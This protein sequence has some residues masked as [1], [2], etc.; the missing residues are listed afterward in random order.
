MRKL[1]AC[2]AAAL[3]AALTASEARA[4]DSPSIVGHYVETRT[5]EVF[6][7]GCLMNSEGETGGREALMAWRIDRGA[8]AGVPLDGLSVVAAVTADVNLGTRELGGVPPSSIRSVVYV[9]DRATRAQRDAL[10]TLVRSLSNGFV[11][12]V[13]AVKPV[14]IGFS[15]DEHAIAVRAGDAA[16]D[17]GTHMAHDTNCS[18][19][20]WFHPLAAIDSATLGVTNRQAYSGALLGRRWEQIDRRSAFFGE[21]RY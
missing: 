10:V 16:I 9:D 6:T 13:V 18:A 19:L 15:R 5:A 11:G 8:F 2:G 12:E 14:A 4:A 20:Q 21:F 3:V 17:V 1:I 7:G